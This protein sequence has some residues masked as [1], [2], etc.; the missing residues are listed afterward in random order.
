LLLDTNIV[1]YFSKG[2]ILDKKI[3]IL[4]SKI[5]V[6]TEIEVFGFKNISEQE[7]SLFKGFFENIEIIDLTSEIKD[8]TISLKQTKKMSLG[9][10]I[11]AATA[12]SKK[13]P[14]VTVNVDDFKWIKDL[15]IINPL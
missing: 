13:L 12:L 15:K 2:I 3:N 14:L 8:I 1:I 7:L 5:S 10:S 4:E 6:V 9:D 11:M